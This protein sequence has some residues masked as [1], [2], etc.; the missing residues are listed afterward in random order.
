MR[1]ALQPTVLQR[2]NLFAASGNAPAT[3]QKTTLMVD[4]ITEAPRRTLSCQ[5]EFLDCP[6]ATK[7]H[8]VVDCV[9]TAEKKKT[10]AEPDVA[11]CLE[12][13]ANFTPIQE[14]LGSLHLHGRPLRHKAQ[15][16]IESTPGNH[17][18]G[19]CGTFAWP[20]FRSGVTGN[21]HRNT[22]A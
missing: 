3:L 9:A 12:T 4:E 1:I 10:R 22:P 16:A 18:F 7:F 19:T 20:M 5:T 2:T 15:D 17:S 8:W 11:G 14:T 6:G 21:H 13:T